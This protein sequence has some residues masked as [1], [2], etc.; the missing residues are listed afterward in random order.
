M[1]VSYGTE[2]TWSA[3]GSM[4]VFTSKE[5]E[6]VLTD[7]PSIL[8]LRPNLLRRQLVSTLIPKDVLETNLSPTSYYSDDSDTTFRL[9]RRVVQQGYNRAQR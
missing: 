7:S 5:R 9:I 6:P 2:P 3:A 8:R 1:F 4:S